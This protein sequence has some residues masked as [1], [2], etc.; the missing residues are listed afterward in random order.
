MTKVRISTILT[1]EEGKLCHLF[2]KGHS[3]NDK[4]I[5]LIVNEIG[6]LNH[7]EIDSSFT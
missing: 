5:G 2:V 7:I 1:N 4:G 6:T 3:F